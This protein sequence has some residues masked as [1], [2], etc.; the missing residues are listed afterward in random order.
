VLSEG[1]SLGAATDLDADRVLFIDETGNVISEDVM[2]AI[3]GKWAFRRAA[4]EG[5]VD[6]VCITPVNSSGLIEYVAREFDVEVQYCMIGQPDTERRLKEFGKRAVYA[7]EESGKYYFALDVHWCDGILATLYLLQIMAERNMT[8]GELASEFPTF[9]QAKAQLRCGDEAKSRVYGRVMELFR[10]E[11]SLLEGR[12]EDITI[13]G[14]K[15]LYSDDSWLLLRPSGT[16]PLFR[17][18]S[19]ALDRGRAEELVRE[20]TKLVQ[21]AIEEF[22]L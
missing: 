15:R 6:P 19:D 10:T 1:A 17:L 13:D 20:G 4:E 12:K 8:L 2:G 14:L 11:A 21:A 9:H 5:I 18:Y 16:E 3:F 22:S 7:Y